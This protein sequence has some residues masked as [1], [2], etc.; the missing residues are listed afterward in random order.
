MSIIITDASVPLSGLNTVQDIIDKTNSNDIWFCPRP[1]D[2]LYSSTSGDWVVCCQGQSNGSGLNT[3]NTSAT[4]WL[5][6]T[7]LNNV[8]REI[9]SGT[10]GESTKRQCERCIVQEERYGTSDRLRYIERLSG[11]DEPVYKQVLDYIETNEFNLKERFIVLQT[12]AFGNQCNLDCYMCHPQNSTTR[13][14]S[15]NKV[16]FNKYISFGGSNKEQTKLSSNNTIE[17]IKELAPYISVFLIQGGEPL[18]MKKQFE[19]LDFLVEHGHSK[20]ITIEMNTNLTILGTTTNSILDYANKFK[21]MDMSISL[22]GVGKYNDYIRRR[23][24]WDTIL[25]NLIKLRKATTRIGVFSTISLLSILHFDELI[26]WCQQENMDQTMFV[27]D[28]PNEL[29]PRHLPQPIKNKL[30]NKYENLGGYG[31]ITSALKLDRDPVKFIKAIEYIKATD[32]QYQTDIYTIYPELKE[33]DND[34]AE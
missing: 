19:F 29:H 8:R 12:R 28:G 26:L 16:D 31:I 14:A 17:E 15:N 30:I 18:V 3:R 13:Q 34:T 11:A 6:S 25:E 22:E 7:P 33:Y 9:L 2:H 1:F 21:N 4:E 20:H 32:I 24:D 5:N 27:I 10:I 23:S